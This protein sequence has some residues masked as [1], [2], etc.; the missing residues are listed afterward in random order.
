LHGIGYDDLCPLDYDIS[1]KNCYNFKGCW[2]PQL[3]YD[4]LVQNRHYFMTLFSM[5]ME[6]TSLVNTFLVV[7]TSKRWLNKL[8]V[9]DDCL[10]MSC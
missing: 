9:L 4:D 10:Y 3:V 6:K 2:P 7:S 5:V 1:D 8:I